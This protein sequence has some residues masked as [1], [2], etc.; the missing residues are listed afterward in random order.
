M[1]DAL[2]AKTLQPLFLT[3]NMTTKAE[4]NPSKPSKLR[5]KTKIR[6]INVICLL[7]IYLIIDK[8]CFVCYH[9]LV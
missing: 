5:N 3:T 2:L 1:F 7:Q 8:S 4:Y 6:K 9:I